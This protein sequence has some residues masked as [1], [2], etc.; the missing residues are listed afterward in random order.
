[1]PLA[2]FADVDL[3]A[4]LKS[5]VGSWSGKFTVH[6][7]ATGFTEAF[8]VEQQYWMDAGK[9]YGVSVMMRGEQMD[10]S[11]SVTV[12]KDDHFY[13][14]VKRGET[15]EQFVGVPKEGGIL[16]LPR[17]MSRAK[18]YQI[19][20]WVEL[21]GGKRLLKTEG[22]DTYVFS[23]GLGHIVYKGELTA[24]VEKP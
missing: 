5:Y 19:R 16:W 20:E 3:A 6:S 18:D 4:L 23:E 14:I 2:L 12:I 10:S 1:L 13:S 11:N 8:E 24:T 7:T 17:N 21:S 22:F 15:E 9:L